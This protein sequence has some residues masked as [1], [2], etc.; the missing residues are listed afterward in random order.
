MQT[1][2]RQ[3]NL[4]APSTKAES[5]ELFVRFVHE[6]KGKKLRLVSVPD[7]PIRGA[8]GRPDLRCIGTQMSKK[9]VDHVF[10]AMV[11]LSH[12]LGCNGSHVPA[13]PSESGTT[14]CTSE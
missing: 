6:H 13:S 9:Q 7:K 2:L 11:T 14:G 5:L 3:P 12:N 8:C 1:L 10:S 4:E